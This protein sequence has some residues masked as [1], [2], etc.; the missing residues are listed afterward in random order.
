MQ[1]PAS[2]CAYML[3]TEGHHSTVSP[4]YQIV[5]TIL[6]RALAGLGGHAQHTGS[7]YLSRPGSLNP[8]PTSALSDP[9]G[10]YL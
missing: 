9:S 10:N 2:R 4:G 8:F 6:A 7:A 1:N 3:I 5:K